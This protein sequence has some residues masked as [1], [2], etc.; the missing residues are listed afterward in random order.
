MVCVFTLICVCSVS[1]K[2]YSRDFPGRP[3]VKTSPSSAERAGS[4]PDGEAKIPR[5]KAKT[6]K[7]KAEAILSEW[8]TEG[9]LLSWV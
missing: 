9:L 2:K 6:P 8:S 5:L 4:T 1:I 3:V 7:H